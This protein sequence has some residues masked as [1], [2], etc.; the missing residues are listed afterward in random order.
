M[1]E[2]DSIAVLSARVVREPQVVREVSPQLDIG[3]VR[4]GHARKRPLR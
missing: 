1:Q 2:L 3:R 4:S